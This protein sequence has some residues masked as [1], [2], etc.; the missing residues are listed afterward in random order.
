MLDFNGMRFPINVILVCIRWYVA[1][2]CSVVDQSLCRNRLFARLRCFKVPVNVAGQIIRRRRRLCWIADRQA[3]AIAR[4][5][6]GGRIGAQQMRREGAARRAVLYRQ[7]NR[8]LKTQV[9]WERVGDKHYE[10]ILQHLE[11]R[12]D[13][14]IGLRSS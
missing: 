5:A 6:T 3:V 12:V 7:C 11:E 14:M 1:Y 2:G 9:L 10:A 8:Q 4:R 13:R